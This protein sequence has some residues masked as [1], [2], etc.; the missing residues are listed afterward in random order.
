[1]LLHEK[2]FVEKN[3]ISFTSRMDLEQCQKA[4]SSTVGRRVSRSC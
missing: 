1:M 2:I 4:L 3:G